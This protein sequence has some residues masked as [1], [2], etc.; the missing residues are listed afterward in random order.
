MHACL[1]TS[2]E[3]ASL[4]NT[5]QQLHT[6]CWSLTGLQD[7]HLCSVHVKKSARQLQP[8]GLEHT[9]P[10]AEMPGIIQQHNMLP[11]TSVVCA[12]VAFALGPNPRHS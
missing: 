12:V 8:M 2:L 10:A 11:T 4:S 9:R 3:H 6:A 5:Q 7:E 1:V